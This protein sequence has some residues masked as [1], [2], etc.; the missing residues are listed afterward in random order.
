MILFPLYQ[1]SRKNLAVLLGKQPL[2]FEKLVLQRNLHYLYRFLKTLSQKQR[3]VFDNI[4]NSYPRRPLSKHISEVFV[5]T[6]EAEFERFSM[7][8]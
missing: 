6:V 5:E 8:K 4:D 1:F 2:D 7:K 3:H